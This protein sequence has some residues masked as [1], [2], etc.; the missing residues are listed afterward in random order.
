M[1]GD[2]CSGI[3]VA[4]Y[5]AAT[6]VQSPGVN[7]APGLPLISAPPE[8]LQSV[9]VTATKRNSSQNPCQGYFSRA[10]G[11]FSQTNSAVAHIAVMGA[12]AIFSG[13]TSRFLY[14][15]SEATAAR[16]WWSGFDSIVTQYG[17]LTTLESAAAVT[18]TTVTDAA[19]V[20]TAFEVGNA[21]GSLVSAIPTGNG[22]TVSGSVSDFIQW[23]LTADYSSCGASDQPGC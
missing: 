18:L 20:Y 11:N 15:T 4:C 23:E 12:K 7:T 2:P 21:V 1:N 9:T 6:W 17:T 10:A 22:N 14:G 13:P 5:D 3:G 16:W 19:A 8:E